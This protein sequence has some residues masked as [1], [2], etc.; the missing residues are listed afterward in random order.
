MHALLEGCLL[1]MWILWPGARY[2][3]AD[4]DTAIE[5][6]LES[7]Y[8]TASDR[9][10][11]ADYGYDLLWCFY[12][13]SATAKNPKLRRVAREMGHERALAWRRVHATMPRGL[14]SDEVVDLIFGSD[15]ADRL[16]VRDP[17][18]KHYLRR[19]AARYTVV[20]F[21]L[22]DPTREPPP[23]DI[24]KD[25]GKCDRHNARGHTMCRYCG[26]PLEMRDRY[27]VWTEALITTYTGDN[28]GVTLGARYSD[29]I[30]WIHVMRPY[31]S[32]AS[33][34]TAAFFNVASAVTHVVYTLNDYGVHRLSPKWLP[35]E[36]QY[37]KTNLEEMMKRQD[38][39]MVG[40][41]LDTL[42]A[43]GMTEADPLIRKGGKYLLSTQNAD[44][45]WGG[46]DVYNRY[47]ST[48]TALDGLR[49]YAWHEKR[50]D[51]RGLKKLSGWNQRNP[52]SR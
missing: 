31:P 47:H 2:T 28:Y 19:M 21:L 32:G 50:L 26:D 15:A 25:C 20:D 35:Q 10:N 11:F 6:G 14:S 37:L 5:R 8:R 18:M 29:V 34:K 1:T 3:A 52:E 17:A 40:E 39:E 23:S 27:D 48:W 49:L 45:S 36:Y 43:F 4:R 46:P 12:T 13:I 42:R 16:G 24:P 51:S 33:L 41:F 9:H 22:F 30:R 44:G 7:I 38:P